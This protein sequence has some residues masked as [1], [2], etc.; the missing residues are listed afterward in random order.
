MHVERCAEKGA[1]LVKFYEHMIIAFF[2][3][4][5][6]VG[7][8]KRTGCLNQG[9]SMSIFSSPPIE[10]PC[11]LCLLFVQAANIFTSLKNAMQVGLFRCLYV[12]GNSDIF[13]A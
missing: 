7:G 6:L 9:H 4:S 8:T 3:N 2:G 11:L 5:K 10:P 12:F 13:L 1:L